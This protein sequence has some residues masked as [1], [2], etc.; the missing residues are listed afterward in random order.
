LTVNEIPGF[1]AEQVA[2][3][4]PEQAGKRQFRIGVFVIAGLIATVFLL[5]LL[6]DPGTFRNRYK[7]TTTVDNVMGLR[8]GDP[9]QMRGV[10]IGRVNGFELGSTGEDVVIILEIEGQWPIPEGSS[11]QL[12]Q[13]GLMAPRTVEVLPG[14]GPGTIV[15]GDAMPGIAVKGLLDDTESLG[16]KGQEVLDRITELLSPE[17]VDAFG[18]SAEGLRTLVGDLSDVVTSEG[19]NLKGLIESLRQAAD[20]LAAVT[21][22]APELREDLA[23]TMASADSL[24]VRLNATS[25]SIE[26]VVG[27]LETILTRMEN[28]E[29]TLGRLSVNDTLFTSLL[30]AAE[31]ARLLMDDVRENP[32]RYINVSI[33]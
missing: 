24:M 12:V 31:S 18:G 11:T 9:V 15:D 8:K 14:P 29:G 28:G 26:G 6:T 30:A 7:V 13:P 10:N 21:A 23:S 32:S 27:S 2:E 4:A 3:V 17:N 16:E 20:G 33:F 19:D 25:E 22:D 1:S 5:Y